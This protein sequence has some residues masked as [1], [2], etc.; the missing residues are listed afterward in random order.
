[1]IIVTFENKIHRFLRGL[2]RS[3]RSIFFL[4]K[5]GSSKSTNAMKELFELFDATMNEIRKSQND[6]D[7]RFFNLSKLVIKSNRGRFN[8]TER[9]ILTTRMANYARSLSDDIKSVLKNPPK[10]IRNENLEKKYLNDTRAQVLDCYA[11]KE[12][13][14]CLKSSLPKIK[15]ILKKANELLKKRKTF[16][17]RSRDSAAAKNKQ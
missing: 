15:F 7:Q 1:M 9:R 4:Q 3:D 5:S 6:F 14:I 12:W 10:W 16:L 11:L 8:Q 13:K 2:F 17:M